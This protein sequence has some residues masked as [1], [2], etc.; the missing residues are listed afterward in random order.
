MSFDDVPVPGPLIYI[1]HHAKF[2]DMSPFW[3][4]PGSLYNP[5]VVHCSR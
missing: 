1:N 2:A 3:P 4:G 5:Q